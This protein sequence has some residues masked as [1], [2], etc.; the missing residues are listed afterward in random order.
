MTAGAVVETAVAAAGLSAM[1]HSW[2]RGRQPP[3][4][5]LA[6]LLDLDAAPD[7]G[8]GSAE[9]QRAVA[10][11]A[12]AMASR[13]VEQLD[14]RGA[15]AEALERARI[16]LRPGE[17]VVVSAAVA[18]A[19]AALLTVVTG[20]PLAGLGGVAGGG[21]AAAFLVRHRIA[22][23]RNRFEGQLPGALSLVASSLAAG[24]TFLRAIQMMCEESDPPL[25]EE[26]TQMVAE[27]RLGFSVV[28]AL[29]RMAA[30]VRVRDLDWVVQAVRIQQTVGGRLAEL[31][32]T[33]ADFI[34]DRDE[35][36]REVRVLTAEGRISAYVLG[37]LPPVL[38]LAIQLLHPEYMAPMYR[39]WGVAV[40]GASG[41]SVVLG[42]WVIFRMVKAIEV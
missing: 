10:K 28:D 5:R 8:P 19:L 22:R 12:V 27:T 30:R 26:F 34:R 32:H 40:L 18:L 11:R 42:T 9:A 4:V 23:R 37:A 3:G 33:L 29:Q 2:F 35:V 6:R 13:L 17:Y 38:L 14:R 36:R 7:P 39:G 24:H 25:A 1:L 31:L 41:T 21:G 15:L 16:P 20:R